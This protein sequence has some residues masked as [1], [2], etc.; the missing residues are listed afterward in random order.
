MTKR[1]KPRSRATTTRTAK[2][3]IDL[4]AGNV[5]LKSCLQALALMILAGLEIRNSVTTCLPRIAPSDRS[6]SPTCA[7]GMRG[8]EFEQCICFG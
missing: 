2:A 1:L 4:L 6:P 8:Q 3:P 7:A 5:L